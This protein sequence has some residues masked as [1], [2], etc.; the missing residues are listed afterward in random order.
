V[1]GIAFELRG[2]K[3]KQGTKVINGSKVPNFQPTPDL[4]VSAVNAPKAQLSTRWSFFDATGNESGQEMLPASEDV[5]G[6][7][8][9]AHE[10]TDF[11]FPPEQI[12]SLGKIKVPGPGQVIPLQL[13]PSL[14][15]YGVVAV[16]GIG[17]GNYSLS[18]GAKGISQI[19]H[20]PGTGMMTPVGTVSLKRPFGASTTPQHFAVWAFIETRGKKQHSGEGRILH[21]ADSL[22]SNGGGSSSDG[23]AEARVY[24]FDGAVTKMPVGDEIEIQFVY[25]KER[26]VKFYFERPKLPSEKK[27]TG[28]GAG[29]STK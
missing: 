9:T 3:L 29:E 11:P 23:R 12:K 27:A 8:V 25:P 21:G 1:D 26:N 13:D 10:F 5:W 28:A 19:F 2:V 16:F 14:A 15:E 24:S 4:K 22:H 6:L 7:K 20:N 18:Y 17:G